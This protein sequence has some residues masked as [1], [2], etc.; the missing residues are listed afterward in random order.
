[1]ISVAAV[2]VDP[3]K[4]GTD[5]G[6]LAGEGAWGIA[7]RPDLRTALQDT[8][9]DIAVHTTGSFLPQVMDQLGELI[10]ARLSICST[11]EELCY[12]ALKHPALARRLDAQAKASG[13]T[14]HGTG[15][16]PGFVM[17]A[18]ALAAS[19][20]CQEV[21]HVRVERIVD[22]SKRRPPLQIKTGAG[23]SPEEFMARADTG[24]VRHAGYQ[25]SV[26]LVAAGLGWQLEEV[27]ETIRPIVATEAV[28]TDVLRVEPGQALGLH[29]EARGFVGGKPVIEMLL[30]MRV[31]SPAGYDR[32]VIDGI[33]PLHVEIVGGTHGD[34]ATVARVVNS[35]PAVVAAP[36]GL[37]TVLDLPLA[38]SWGT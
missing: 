32:V 29:Q 6:I 13:V 30:E 26:A 23:L 1:M 2:D 35:L 31:D 18:F 9:A 16:N 8:P 10:E 4:I 20:V 3:A 14:V 7:V 17:D 37:A 38:P 27:E 36:P 12:P 34:R 25:E 5:L 15:V 33:P 11:C 21:S 28:A 22:A 19:S 24:A